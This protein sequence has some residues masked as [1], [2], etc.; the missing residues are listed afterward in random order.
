MRIFSIFDSKCQHY[1]SHVQE[2]ESLSEES[3]DKVSGLMKQVHDARQDPL[4]GNAVCICQRCFRLQQYGQVE[5]GLRPGWSENE[6][7]TP[8]RFESLLTQIRETQAVV[9]CIV[10]IFDLEGSLLRNLKKIAGNNP[11]V[12][13]ANKVDLLPIDTSTARLTSWIHSE[14]K[15][16]CGL[17]SPKEAEADIRE[18]LQQVVLLR[19]CHNLTRTCTPNL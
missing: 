6:L 3:F 17:V 5:E 9:L 19:T 18:E 16:Y 15:E 14:V 7:L 13:A 2:E 12:I 1:Q 8:E 11:I 10:D 4:M